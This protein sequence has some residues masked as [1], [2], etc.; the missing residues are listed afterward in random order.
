MLA[1]G[2]CRRR[3]AD[4][5][6]LAP[7][8]P[9]PWF[10]GALPSPSPSPSAPGIPKPQKETIVRHLPMDD[11]AKVWTI[12]RGADGRLDERIDLAFLASFDDDQAIDQLVDALITAA[13]EQDIAETRIW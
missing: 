4:E 7:L 3:R 9:T 13:A 2:G 1:N 11:K 8:T 6:H 5:P 10:P 12:T